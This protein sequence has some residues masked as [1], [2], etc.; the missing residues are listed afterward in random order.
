MEEW[1]GSIWHKYIMQK[2]NTEF[3][4]ARVE[5]NDI[6]KSTGLIFRALGGS[7]GKR[8]EAAAPRDYVIRRTL[9]ERISGSKLQISLAWQDETSLRLPQSIAIF[10]NPKLNKEL[11]LWLAVLAA[12]SPTKFTHWAKDNQAIVAKILRKYPSLKSRYQVLVNAILKQRLALDK[13]PKPLQALELAV[14]QAI[15]HPE[16]KI[17]F[18]VTNYAPQ[19]IYIW[20]YPNANIKENPF[21]IEDIPLSENDEEETLNK[22]ES[23]QAR[24]KSE[25]IDDNDSKDSL[26]IFRLENLFSW[27]E[28]SKVNRA[29]DDSEDD[30]AQ[31]VAEDLDLITV[32]EPNQQKTSK[33]KIDLDLPSAIEDDLPLG[34]GIALPEWDYK[35]SRLIAKRCLLQPMLPR[36]SKPQPLPLPLRTITKKIR[37]QFEHLQTLKNWQKGLQIGDEI[38]LD[39]WLDFHIESTTSGAQ[40]EGFYQSFQRNN[41]DI[42]CILLSDLSMSTDAHI[43]NEHKVID[44]IKDS[45]LLF[46]EALEAVG[47]TFAIYGFS[48]VKRH[49]VRFTLLKNFNEKYSDII[50]GRILSIR[51]GFY[52]RMGAAIR[53]A[54]DILVQEKRDKKLLLILTDGKPNDIDH[55]EGRFGIEDT[56]QAIV[57]A[58]RLGLIPFCITIDQQADQYLPYIFGSNGFTVILNPSQLP[59]KLPLLYHQLTQ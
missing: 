48:S 33:I 12:H 43:N 44:V 17:E 35:S 19:A 26:M 29:E 32:S 1:I 5:F 24:K 2:S 3:D 25:R 27:S 14:I 36:N 20:L 30:D 23:R 21:S 13:L 8:I 37:S 47:D 4:H 50:R 28:F 18:P 40:E 34:E 51:P 15:K 10:D 42:S 46:S 16:N 39:A 53:Q 56:K 49:H 11:Y 31:R 6:S 9:L 58:R 59:V 55:Y 52:T 57:A 54:S 45:M 38:D 7:A 41:R 22:Q